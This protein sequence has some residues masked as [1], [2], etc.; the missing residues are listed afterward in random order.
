MRRDIDWIKAKE[1]AERKV[2]LYTYTLKVLE[3]L[4]SSKWLGKHVNKSIID[5][6][7]KSDD[8]GVF[9]NANAYR[10]EHKYIHIY[11][12]QHYNDHY[13]FNVSLNKDDKLELVNLFPLMQ[14]VTK[15][16]SDNMYFLAN[17]EQIKANE[18][19]LKSNLEE[20]NRAYGA[21]TDYSVLYEYLH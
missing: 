4:E 7:P 3:A 18:A 8:F 19:V 2:K 20:A 14:E 12:K 10:P 16:R 21:A 5:S 17:F 6:V 1:D 15:R 11:V 13:E 9:Y